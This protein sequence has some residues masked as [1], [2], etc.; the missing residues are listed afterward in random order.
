MDRSSPQQLQDYIWAVVAAGV[1]AGGI[2]VM[3]DRR[4]SLRLVGLAI[5]AIFVYWISAGAWR[6]TRWGCKAPDCPRH[7]PARQSGDA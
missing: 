6:R 4:D 2:Y 7:G 1:A 3:V 5:V